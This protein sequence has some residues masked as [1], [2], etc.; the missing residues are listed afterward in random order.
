MFRPDGNVN[1]L[2]SGVKLVR[3][4]I[5]GAWRKVS[6]WASRNKSLS[7]AAV[8]FVTYIATWPLGMY[9]TPQIMTLEERMSKAKEVK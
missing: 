9:K 2:I 3:M 6:E 8:L 7:L 1:N 4:S 5:G